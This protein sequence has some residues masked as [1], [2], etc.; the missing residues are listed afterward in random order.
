MVLSDYLAFL[1]LTTT[2][3][4]EIVP[5]P[6]STRTQNVNVSTKPL[7]ATEWIGDGGGVWLADALPDRQ[8]SVD[9]WTHAWFD[10][11]DY[12]GSAIRVYFEVWQQD[13]SDP[14]RAYV[15]EVSLGKAS[16]GAS[17]FYL[18]LA[19]GSDVP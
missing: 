11:S 14:S 5:P 6:T 13:V 12:A 18:P 3:F 10:M 16:G 1:T 8:T 19:L 17:R 7:R 4:D 15:D 9:D 2:S